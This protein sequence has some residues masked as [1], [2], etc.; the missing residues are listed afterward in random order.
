MTHHTTYT[1]PE[2]D[3]HVTVLPAKTGEENWGGE[4]VRPVYSR[5]AVSSSA[6]EDE[7]GFLKIRG[8]YYRVGSRR[9]RSLDQQVS[10]LGRWRWDSP[11]LRRWE[12]TNAEGKEL[13]S[14]TAADRRLDLMVEEAAD[15][16]E[17]QY[18]YWRRNSERLE[19]ED[20]LRS[21]EA[22]R[23]QVCD[24]LRKTDAKIIDLQA[25]IAAYAEVAS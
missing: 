19:L 15:R 24:E 2:G 6:D 21:T 7:P 4:R 25:R 14:G 23:G 17:A 13:G 10:R 8:R 9:I 22:H 20:N 16:F 11:L 3:L 18:P 5:L 12:Y 1:F